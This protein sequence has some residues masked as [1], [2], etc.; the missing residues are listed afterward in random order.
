MRSAEEVIAYLEKLRLIIQYLGASDCKLQE[1]SMRADVNLSVREAGQRGLRDEDGDEEL[2]TPSAPSPG[3]SR[4]SGSA[5]S[6]FWRPGARWSRRPGAGTMQQGLLL[7]HALQGGRPGLPVLPGA[8]SGAGG[9]QRRVAG[10]DP[11][12]DSRSSAMRSGPATKK[13]TGSPITIS[14]SSPRKRGWRIF[15]RRPS[16]WAASPRRFPTG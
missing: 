9:D 5:R 3:P 6:T 15:S 1:G 4:A 11:E 16:P 14:T 2:S 13:N 12:A 8:G 10:G 7:R